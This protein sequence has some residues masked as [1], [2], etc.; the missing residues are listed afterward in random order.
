MFLLPWRGVCAGDYP[1][2]CSF[3]W[4]S[5]EGL[6]EYWDDALRSVITTSFLHPVCLTVHFNPLRLFMEL[7]LH[8]IA[9]IEDKVIN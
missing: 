8:C 2:F 9:Y 1:L 6:G 5:S 7:Y 3:S 4:S